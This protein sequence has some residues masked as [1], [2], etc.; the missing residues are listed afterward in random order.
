MEQFG[1][2]PS[3]SPPLYE[4]GG[5]VFLLDGLNEDLNRGE[6]EN[7]VRRLAGRNLVIVTSQV[8]PGWEGNLMVFPVELRPFGRTQLESLLPVE[9]VQQII[10]N[11][12]L[13]EWARLPQAAILLRAYW[14]SR[15]TLPESQ[16][17]LYA[18]L[19]DRV[20]DPALVARLEY[21]AWELFTAN[22]VLFDADE[23]IPLTDLE[24]AREAAILT[25]REEGAGIHFMFV[26][27]RVSRFLIARYLRRQEVMS[28][29]EWNKSLAAGVER[30]QW[31]VVLAFW[32][33]LIALDERNSLVG[34][35]TY[36]AF[37]DEVM[38]F[39]VPALRSLYPEASRLAN[40]GFVTL[41]PEF[42]RR[43]ADAL[44]KPN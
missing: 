44:A 31:N 15:K 28:L 9:V 13:L 17:E 30:Q 5:L 33:E 29:G 3:D 37:L 38:T 42:I 18:A 2:F 23:S 36:E 39:S 41:S 34:A 26:H 27:E 16:V 43:V 35:G 12:R 14:E 10:A 32:A 8:S 11:E 20:G 4:G 6:T 1:S 24:R 22:Q 21:K 7:F 25:R 40:L 19:V